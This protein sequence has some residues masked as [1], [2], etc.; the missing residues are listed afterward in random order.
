M[1]L[2]RV[3]DSL[4]VKPSLKATSAQRGAPDVG[5]KRSREPPNGGCEARDWLTSQRRN[6]GRGIGSAGSVSGLR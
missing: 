1:P 4:F 5:Q 6:N 3:L 2:D